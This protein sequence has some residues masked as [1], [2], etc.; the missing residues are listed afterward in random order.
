MDTRTACSMSMSRSAEGQK[1]GTV[2][3]LPFSFSPVALPRTDQLELAIA[4]TA[5]ALAI[6][7]QLLSSLTCWWRCDRT[8]GSSSQEK[9]AGQVAARHST[10]HSSDGSAAVLSHFAPLS[11]RR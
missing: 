6:A 5:L 10:G 7:C 11:L 8:D 9:R 3:L 2:D 4:V 1:Q